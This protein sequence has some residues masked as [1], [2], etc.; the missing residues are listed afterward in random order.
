MAMAVHGTIKTG[1]R[2][3]TAKHFISI[4][5]L[6]SMTHVKVLDIGPSTGKK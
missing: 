2:Y 5:T 1:V 6:I 4:V 3:T